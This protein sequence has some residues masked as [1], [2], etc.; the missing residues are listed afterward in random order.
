MD[1]CTPCCARH[2]VGCSSEGVIG[3]ALLDSSVHQCIVLNL[4]IQCQ[5]NADQLLLCADQAV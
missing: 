4:Q 2:H 1:G 5:V 3:R